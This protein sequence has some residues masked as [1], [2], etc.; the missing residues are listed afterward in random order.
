MS[1]YKN[2][3]RSPR[4]VNKYISLCM[5]RKLRVMNVSFRKIFR[6]GLYQKESVSVL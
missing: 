2:G 4:E 1:S 5:I 6:G 3:Y